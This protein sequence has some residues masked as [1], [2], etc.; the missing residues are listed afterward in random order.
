M[1]Y[2]AANTV[3]PLYRPVRTTSIM[4]IKANQLIRIISAHTECTLTAIRFESAF[5]QSTSLD[6]LKPD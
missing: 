6:G 2:R 4:C 5:S 1:Y 3:E